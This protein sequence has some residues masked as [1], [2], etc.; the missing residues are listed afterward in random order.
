MARTFRIR[1]VRIAALVTAILILGSAAV[2][3]FTDASEVE[4]STEQTDSFVAPH[5]TQLET[6]P[7]E[8]VSDDNPPPASVGSPSTSSEGCLNSSEPECGPFHWIEEPSSNEPIHIAIEVTPE[9]PT[10]GEQVTMV[11]KVWDADA[12]LMATWL[13]SSSWGESGTALGHAVSCSEPAHGPW[14]PPDPSPGSET[15]TFTHTYEK[16]GTFALTVDGFSWSA[17]PWGEASCHYPERDPY[18]S[19]DHASIVIT[20]SPAPASPTPS[21]SDTVSPTPT[22]TASPFPAASPT[23]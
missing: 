19:E 11:V 4:G 3:A 5:P 17:P 23:P 21:P 10:V 8:P 22:D 12:P 20:V 14:M 13:P 16:A 2:S 6:A 1:W 7:P 18:G 9:H 15:F